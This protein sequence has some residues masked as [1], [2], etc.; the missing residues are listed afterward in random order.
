MELIMA[1]HSADLLLKRLLPCVKDV[2]L[3]RYYPLLYT[4]DPGIF[5][6]M[7]GV[8]LKELMKKDCEPTLMFTHLRECFPPGE[9]DLDM[10][11]RI[12]IRIKTEIR[13]GRN[14]ERALAYLEDHLYEINEE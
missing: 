4:Y 10:I 14:A 5:A 9:C 8:Q 7:I 6:Y 13:K 2:R 11:K 12:L 1:T 3:Q